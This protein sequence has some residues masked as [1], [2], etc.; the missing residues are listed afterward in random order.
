MGYFP[1]STSGMIYDDKWCSRC[2]HCPQEGDM[3]MCP[4]MFAHM[5]WNYEAV[6]Q[7]DAKSL[8]EA[9]IPTTKDGFPDKCKMF[10]STGDL[11]GQAKL[12]DRKE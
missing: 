10:I 7:E 3:E 12:F 8:L 4:I 6:E 1:N 11:Q 5:I 2:L 9:M